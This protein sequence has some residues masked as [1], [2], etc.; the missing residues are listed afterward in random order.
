MAGLGVALRGFGKALGKGAG[1]VHKAMGS[2]SKFSE[3]VAIGG[4]LGIAATP[5]IGAGVQ[6][7]KKY[8]KS[9]ESLKKLKKAAEHVEYLRSKMK[10]K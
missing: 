6:E 9:K 10:S 5:V 4:G 2:K 8:K 7:F 3:G 1:K